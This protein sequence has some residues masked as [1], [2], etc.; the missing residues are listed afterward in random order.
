MDLAAVRAAEE[1]LLT[2]ATRRNRSRLRGLLHPDFVEIGRSGRRWT[3]DQIVAALADEDDRATPRTDEWELVE[4]GSDLALVTYIIR[5]AA[6]DSRHS[7]IWAR[8]E[9]QLQMRFHQ[10]TPIAPQ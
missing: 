7:S 1:E 8:D 9:G 6:G 4:L 3:R 10:G 2:S 5:N